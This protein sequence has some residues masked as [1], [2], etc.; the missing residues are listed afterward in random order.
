MIVRA[1]VQHLPEH[2]KLLHY[3]VEMVPQPQLVLGDVLLGGVHIVQVASHL[4]W[5]IQ[6]KLAAKKQSD[7]EMPA[8]VK[9]ETQKLVLDELAGFAHAVF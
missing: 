5:Q 4:G 1:L 7:A 2:L 3:A 8:I 6:H 9:Y